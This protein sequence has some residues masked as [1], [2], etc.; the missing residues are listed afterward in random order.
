MIFP[1]IKLTGRQ[2]NLKAFQDE[3]KALSKS[4]L[5]PQNVSEMTKG[6]LGVFLGSEYTEHKVAIKR[7][8]NHIK[9]NNQG[10][11]VDESE[12][13]RK[14]NLTLSKIKNHDR[15]L[16]SA[17]M[18]HQG[19]FSTESIGRVALNVLE[20]K[21]IDAR[22]KK[23]LIKVITSTASAFMQ[24]HKVAGGKYLTSIREAK[25]SE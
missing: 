19:S 1:E 23:M 12:T 5:N 2:A 14:I 22:K 17:G 3:L 7:A 15:M 6:L 4:D 9:F 10:K 8:L 25:Y 20:S 18:H 24:A 16:L 21:E 11:L 13:Y